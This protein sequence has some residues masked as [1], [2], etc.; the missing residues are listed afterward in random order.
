MRKDGFRN[1]SLTLLR[2]ECWSVLLPDSAQSNQLIILLSATLSLLGQTEDSASGLLRVL[3]RSDH[4]FTRECGC[5]E[6][7]SR[8]GAA[9]AR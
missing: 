5:A 2:R 4:E 7:Y 1:I 9:L 3:Q 8:E 6:I